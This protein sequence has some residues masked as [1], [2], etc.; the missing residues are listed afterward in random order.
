MLGL[1]Y[2]TSSSIA[3]LLSVRIHDDHRKLLFTTSF[4]LSVYVQ[5]ELHL[6]GLRKFLVTDPLHMIVRPRLEG[7]DPA[8]GSPTATLLRL[9]PRC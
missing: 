5:R 9:L 6:F 4:I 3:Q 8:A 1:V 7:G 2:L